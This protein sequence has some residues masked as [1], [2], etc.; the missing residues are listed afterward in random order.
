LFAVAL[1]LTLLAA[2]QASTPPA[3]LYSALLKKPFT[4]AELPSGFTSA[5]V[6]KEAPSANGKRY[7]VVGEV[8]VN[9]LG[10]DDADVLRY[11]VF[12]TAADARGDFLHPDRSGEKVTVVGKVPGVT[13]P[14][15]EI[16][17]SLSGNGVTA[18]ALL[19]GNAIVT[20]AAVTMSSTTHASEPHTLALLKAGLAHL[21]SVQH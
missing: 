1:A 11:Y 21:S 12:P 18:M 10:P 6:N 3:A 17:G 13:L 15:W 4:K 16:N 7:H 19:S 14:S 9:V 20:S 5:T 2:G 8:Q